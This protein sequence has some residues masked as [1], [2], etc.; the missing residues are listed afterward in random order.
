MKATGLHL[1]LVGVNHS[2][3]PV[4]FRE[5]LAISVDQRRDA[6]ISLLDYVPQG[7]ILST[8]NRTE[9]YAAD[10]HAHRAD[11]ASIDFLKARANTADGELLPHTYRYQDK[12]AIRHLFLVASGLNS[13]IIGEHEI[14]G[15]VARALE[16]VEELGSI[17]LPLRNLFRQAVRVGRRVRQETDVSK[18]SLSVSSVAVDLVS[19]VV[20]DLA[21]CRILVIGAGDAGRLVVEAARKRGASQIAVTNRSQDRA[22]ALAA[23]LGG[24]VVPLYN[25]GEALAESDVVV[26]C[27]GAP[28]MILD[29]RSVEEAMRLRPEQP[30]VIVDIAVPR[31][32]EPEVSQ[33]ENVFLYNIDHLNELSG[34]NR[35]QRQGEIEKAT[36][37]IDAEAD[38]FAHWWQTLS[39]RPTI[40]A[41]VEKAERIR[42]AQL[43]L[44]FKKIPRLSD[45]ER[46][47]LEAMTKAIVTKL[48]HDPIQHLKS[49]ADGKYDCVQLV[50]ELFR[51]RPEEME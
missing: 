13:M 46:E 5:K 24:K 8:C 49:D 1:C 16:E 44:T 12:E 32:V 21:S 29:R 11:Q 26:S 41:L 37:I 48:L 25:L 6:A 4:D 35:K 23:K 40:G 9:V 27:T 31:D 50:N 2:T 15:Q 33:I 36:T 47:S 39:V 51:L 34:W 10:T 3:T 45:E 28:H 43:D 20:G 17:E 19:G 30:L 22:A 42:R 14:L 7:V 18:G 38:K